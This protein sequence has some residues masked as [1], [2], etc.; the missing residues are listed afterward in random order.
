MEE[1]ER[2][3]NANLVPGAHPLTVE[4]A[5]RGGQNSAKK[6]KERKDRSQRILDLFDTA[7]KNPKYIERMRELGKDP[8]GATL[9][10]LLDASVAASVVEKGDSKS[11]RE[12]KKEAYGE[13]D[14]KTS[15]EVSGEVSGITINVKNFSKGDK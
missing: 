7:L 5:S 6:K 11:W 12:L 8:E 4:E 2:P 13:L 15:L 14:S 9:E 1:K 3:Q 10:D